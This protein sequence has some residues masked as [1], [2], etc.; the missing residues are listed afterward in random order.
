[1]SSLAILAYMVHAMALLPVT[2]LVNF[3]KKATIVL[4]ET[5]VVAVCDNT[6]PAR[7]NLQLSLMVTITIG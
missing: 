2:K 7:V 4:Q 6:L 5:P 1:M 3:G